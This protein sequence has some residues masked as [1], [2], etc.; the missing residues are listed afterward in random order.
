ML[1][2]ITYQFHDPEGGADPCKGA[3]WGSVH[4]DH[5]SGSNSDSDQPQ[6][7]GGEGDL[8]EENRLPPVRDRICRGPCQ[9]L[10]IPLPLLQ[11]WRR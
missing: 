10:A 2:L 9:R 8:G 4:L 5:L 3:E 1:Y 11:E 6:R 7:G